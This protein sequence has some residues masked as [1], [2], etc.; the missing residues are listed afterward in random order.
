MEAVI[1]TC[2]L[3]ARR[4]VEI[5][6]SIWRRFP[7]PRRFDPQALLKP[8]W[9]V[10][11]EWPSDS[12]GWRMGGEQYFFAVRDMYRALTPPQ[13]AAYDRAFPEP[14]GWTGYFDTARRG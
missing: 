11:P 12:M 6:D 2:K 13:Q 1:I 7:P 3:F 10:K 14:P 8:P 9:I 4:L 5:R